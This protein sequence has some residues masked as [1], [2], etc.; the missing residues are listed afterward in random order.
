MREIYVN[1]N[2]FTLAVDNYFFYDLNNEL[3][4]MPEEIHEVRWN[5]TNGEVLYDDGRVE[6]ITELNDI[7]QY[8]SIFET[9]RERELESKQQTTFGDVV[10]PWTEPEIPEDQEE[11]DVEEWLRQ[12]HEDNPADPIHPHEEEP[13]A[14]PSQ[15]E[16]AEDFRSTRNNLL[17]SSDWT[18]LANSPLTD[19]EKVAWESYRQELRDAPETIDSSLWESMLYNGSNPNWP[20]KPS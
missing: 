15:E 7:D 6:E 8:I 5:G 3:S 12:W 14:P 1:Q 2:T 19:A 20:T 16:I 4:F 18:Q 13:P 17:T 10:T 11:Y 9:L